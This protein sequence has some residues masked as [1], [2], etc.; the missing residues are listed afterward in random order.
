VL[1]SASHLKLRH[2]LSHLLGPPALLSV[3][4]HRESH[5][6]QGTQL[7]V[8]GYNNTRSA[9]VFLD[10]P[11]RKLSITNQKIQTNNDSSSGP[12][13]PWPLADLCIWWALPPHAPMET[14]IHGARPARSP[15]SYSR[16]TMKTLCVSS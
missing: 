3:H 11:G 2:Y 4:S 15:S 5:A 10:E 7:R 13:F 12:Q 9:L 16:L 6:V 8:Y 1:I 14:L